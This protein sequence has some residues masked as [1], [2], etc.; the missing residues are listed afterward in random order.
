MVF[1]LRDFFFFFFP[2]CFY[3]NDFFFTHMTP[4]AIGEIGKKKIKMENAVTR[5]GEVGGTAKGET[6]R[7]R[8]TGTYVSAECW[9]R[10]GGRVRQRSLKIAGAKIAEHSSR[11]CDK[12]NARSTIADVVLT[13]CATCDIDFA[14]VK[15][16][17]RD[18]VRADR[19]DSR[20]TPIWG[21]KV[22][23]K[24]KLEKNKK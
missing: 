20:P 21:K 19:S 4:R 23:G 1:F 5:K 17:L 13:L 2:L 15:T 9:G 6:V 24:I 12:R 18:S 16:L 14:K 11:D 22:R 10:G 3:S 7:A 8:H